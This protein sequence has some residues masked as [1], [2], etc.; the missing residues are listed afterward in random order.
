M[1]NLLLGAYDDLTLIPLVSTALGVC[2]IAGPAV[3]GPPSN[4]KSRQ[5][6]RISDT[7]SAF[8][9]LA[10]GS[11]LGGPPCHGQSLLVFETSDVIGARR[12]APYGVQLSPADRAKTGNQTHAETGTARFTASGKPPQTNQIDQFNYNPRQD[13][14]GCGNRVIGN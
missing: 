11:T 10:S 7:E 2:W 8:T 14:S 12:G 4:F 5:S 3:L 1:K 9:A 6:T 13:N